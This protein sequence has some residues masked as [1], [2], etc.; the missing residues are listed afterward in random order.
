M[1]K[2]FIQPAPDIEKLT[3]TDFRDLGAL[4]GALMGRY[5]ELAQVIQK[6]NNEY[7]YWDKFKHLQLSHGVSPDQAWYILKISRTSQRSE[8]PI[9]DTD[10]RPFGFWL[11]DSALRYLHNI[12]RQAPKLIG[13]ELDII[14]E[15]SKRQYLISSLME[16]A[17]ASSQMEG[18]ST[19]RKVAKELLRTGRKPLTKA[20]RMIVNNYRTI[21]KIIGLK[22]EKLSLDMLLELQASITEGILDPNEVGKLRISNDISVVD[23]TSYE[24]LH[25]PPPAQELRERIELLCEFANSDEHDPRFMHPIIKGILLHFWLAYIHPFPDGNGR[26]ARALF[27]WH[28]LA[29]DYWLFEYLPISYHLK[30][31]RAQYERAFLHAEQDGNDATYFIIYH[32][33][34]IERALHSLQAYLA[35]KQKEYIETTRLIIKGK[36]GLNYRQQAIIKHAL[37]RP[38]FIYTVESHRN[39]HGVTPQTARSDLLSLVDQGLLIFNQVGKKHRFISPDDLVERISKDRVEAQDTNS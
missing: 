11:P 7:Y 18:A 31:S 32:L 15:A 16:E 10:S 30:K 6:A 4:I 21:Q 5:G 24:I 23:S 8:L 38:G 36:L 33:K 27:Y 35:K 25:D 28:M 22:K 2:R 13:A 12:D 39:S 29:N 19:T 37:K 17:I 34:A 14:N 1:R 9:T 20:E 26:T 3:G